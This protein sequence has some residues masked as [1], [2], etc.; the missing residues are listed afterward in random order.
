MRSVDALI[1][2][3]MKSELPQQE[4]KSQRETQGSVKNPTRAS[5]TLVTNPD[6][7]SALFLQQKRERKKSSY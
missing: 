2:K 1:L 6:F 5:V 4:G 7:K 3:E